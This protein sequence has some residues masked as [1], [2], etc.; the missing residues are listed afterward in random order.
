[1]PSMGPLQRGAG[2]GMAALGP[3]NWEEEDNMDNVFI[4]ICF[5]RV[6]DRKFKL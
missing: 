3:G 1:M 2:V 4:L 5:P 6:G